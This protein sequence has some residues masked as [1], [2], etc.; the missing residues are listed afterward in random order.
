MLTVSVT[1]WPG[2]RGRWDNASSNSQ[3]RNSPNTFSANTQKNHK[4]SV[5]QRNIEKQMPRN[6]PLGYK[7]A[8]RGCKSIWSKQTETRMEPFECSLRKCVLTRALVGVCVF[9]SRRWKETAS[10]G[11]L[12]YLPQAVLLS[13]FFCSK[14]SRA[15]KPLMDLL[16]ASL[17]VPVTIPDAL[18]YATNPCYLRK[19]AQLHPLQTEAPNEWY[20][21]W[22]KACVL[23]VQVSLSCSEVLEEQQ[24]GWV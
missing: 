2:F 17:S 7:V 24:A 15:T 18:I 8:R 14:L 9:C 23:S 22:I 6:F 19:M 11:R 13:H 1:D 12:I 3:L 10:E 4:G 16:P 20:I 5:K 21:T